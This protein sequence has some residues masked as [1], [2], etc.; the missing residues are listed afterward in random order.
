MS[1]INLS[2]KYGVNPS[3][4]HCECCGKT[5]G[6][7]MFGTSWKDENGKTEKAPMDVTHGLCN[8]C[9]SVIDN[10]GLMLIEVRDGESGN[11]PYR[12]G[13]IIGLS[14]EFKER[15]N[16]KHSIAYMPHSDFSAMFKDVQFNS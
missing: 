4:A 5:Y 12:T 7:V 1:E 9:Q 11:N 8:E 6:V 15:N 16:I 13:R 3:V 14:K 2:K 10:G